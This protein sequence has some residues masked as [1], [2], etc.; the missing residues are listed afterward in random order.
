MVRAR[1]R[2]SVR[3]SAR[4]REPERVWE[5]E[6]VPESEWVRELAWVV[7]AREPEVV[8]LGL[9]DRHHRRRER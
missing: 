3:A 6:R 2:A 1:V 7:R 4:V 8:A 9:C 5:L